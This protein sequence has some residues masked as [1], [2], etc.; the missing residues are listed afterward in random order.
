MSLRGEGVGIFLCLNS[1]PNK[2]LP[3]FDRRFQL[4]RQ[5]PLRGCCSAVQC[6][7]RIV[8]Q[9]RPALENFL[10][11]YYAHQ[12][13]ICDESLIKMEGKCC[14]STACPDLGLSQEQDSP[15]P[16][17]SE[18]ELFRQWR[19]S[20]PLAWAI[21]TDSTCSMSSAL[22]VM[23]RRRDKDDDSDGQ[24]DALTVQSHL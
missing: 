21:S 13:Q 24:G 14:H 10:V 15:E 23:R 17:W 8:S 4:C 12:T 1:L 20:S 9:L 18:P 7:V 2:C 11:G 6:S 3:K 16:G 5:P 22:V 19:P